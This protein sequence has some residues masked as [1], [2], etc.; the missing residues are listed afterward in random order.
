[1]AFAVIVATVNYV[2][3]GGVDMADRKYGLFP[4]FLTGAFALTYALILILKR[5]SYPR[6][7]LYIGMNTI[8]FYGLH[9]FV[10]ELCFIAYGKIGIAFDPSSL[11]WVA[12]A[13]LN[14]IITCVAIYPIS[15]AINNK[16]PWLI[17]KY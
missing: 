5:V 12:L 16:C 15:V 2:G 6:R 9:R 1:L 7:M 8:I 3:Y 10:I 14:V 11:L 4:L 13:V 17:G